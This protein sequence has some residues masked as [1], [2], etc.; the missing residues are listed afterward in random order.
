MGLPKGTKVTMLRPD[1]PPVDVT[2]AIMPSLQDK[3][4]QR[5]T[6]DVCNLIESHMPR[7]WECMTRCQEDAEAA[8]DDTGPA[9]KV[10]LSVTL[11]PFG[12]HTVNVKAAIYYGTKVKDATEEIDS[13]DH[14][15][16]DLSKK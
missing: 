11:T 3:V 14:P 15:E 2:A 8:G 12:R 10:A 16:L 1:A 5:A 6:A 13:T 7:I 4:T 9:Y